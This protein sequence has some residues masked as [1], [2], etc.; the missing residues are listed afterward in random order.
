MQAS[1]LST[2]LVTKHFFGPSINAAK[3]SYQTERQNYIADVER[4]A[5][6]DVD[7]AFERTEELEKPFFVAQMGW[8]R[9]REAIEKEESALQR[10]GVAE[11]RVKVLESERERAWKTRD[12]RR[13]E[14][15][16]ATKRNALDPKTYQETS[17]ASQKRENDRSRS[18]GYFFNLGISNG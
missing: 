5:L 14:Q 12:E 16:E 9:A 4:V 15:E 18:S 10:A 2:E 8:H 13:K 11:E 3:T 6:E 7:N 1:R 17:K